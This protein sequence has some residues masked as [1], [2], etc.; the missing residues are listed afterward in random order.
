MRRPSASFEV[1]AL[2]WLL[3]LGAAVFSV[4]GCLTRDDE[5]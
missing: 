5:K 2:A 4:V 1:I 3:G